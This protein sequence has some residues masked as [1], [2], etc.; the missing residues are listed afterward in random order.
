MNFGPGDPL[1][2]HADDERVA[3]DQIR[4]TERALREWLTGAAR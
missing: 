1:K 4:S 2:A 3:L